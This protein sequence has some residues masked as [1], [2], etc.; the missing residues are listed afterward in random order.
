MVKLWRRKLWPP[1]RLDSGQPDQEEPHVHDDGH[2]LDAF[3]VHGEMRDVGRVLLIEHL[4]RST[5]AAA[6]IP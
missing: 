6:R 2:L 4:G 5:H 1:S 3:L